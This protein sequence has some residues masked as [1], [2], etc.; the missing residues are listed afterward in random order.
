MLTLR[1]VRS[2]A[3]VLKRDSAND[4]TITQMFIRRRNRASERYAS[5]AKDH[6]DLDPDSSDSSDSD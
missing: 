2:A 4:I 6:E 5:G 3:Y 1:T